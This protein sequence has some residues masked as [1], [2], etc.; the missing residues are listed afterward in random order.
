MNAI[1][2]FIDDR[3]AERPALL[4]VLEGVLVGGAG[5]ADG[6]APTAGRV[7]S[8]VAIAGC[9]PDEP[10]LGVLQR[11]AGPGQLLVELLLAAEQARA[12]DAHVVEHHLGG[13]RGLDAVLLVLLAHRQPG[14]VRAG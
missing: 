9:L 12:G 10:S 14:R 7:A 2:W 3:L 1:D 8:K 13:V 11:L 5:D 4:G 6:L